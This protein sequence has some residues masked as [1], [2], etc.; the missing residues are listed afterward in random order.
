MVTISETEKVT[1]PLKLINII[2]EDADLRAIL[3]K[4]LNQ[5]V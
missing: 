1:R 5:P 2:K 4:L 3:E